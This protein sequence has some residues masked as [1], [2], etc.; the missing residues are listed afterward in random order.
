MK[1][2]ITVIGHDTVGVIARVSGLCS[3]NSLFIRAMPSP[4]RLFSVSILALSVTFGATSP[5]GR[6]F[7]QKK[8]FS[9]V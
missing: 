8:R 1:A 7:C 4:C 5:K 6:G 2:F 9:P 3:D